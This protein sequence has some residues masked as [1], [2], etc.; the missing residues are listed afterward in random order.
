MCMKVCE[1]YDEETLLAHAAG[2]MGDLGIR[3]VEQHV[4]YCS[5][6]STL[7]RIH[8]E[9]QQPSAPEPDELLKQKGVR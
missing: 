6:C 2:E 9:S 3:A 4:K 7:L 1:Q 5:I 8:S